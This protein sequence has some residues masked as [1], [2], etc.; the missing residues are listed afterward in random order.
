[1]EIDYAITTP[2]VYRL[3]VRVIPLLPL[4]DAK[5]WIGWIY[6]NPFFVK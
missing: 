3:E 2:G 1:M 4:P 6:T 5:K